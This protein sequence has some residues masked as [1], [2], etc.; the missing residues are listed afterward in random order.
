ML[1]GALLVLALAAPAFAQ[2]DS[3]IV[4][5]QRVGWMKVGMDFGIVQ[6][7]FGDSPC[8][9]GQANDMTVYSYDVQKFQFYVKNNKVVF[10]LTGNSRYRLASGV[11]IGSDKA[12]VVKA[13]GKP[14]QDG[15]FMV[16]ESGI[17]LRLKDGAV[18]EIVVIKTGGGEEDSSV[19]VAGRKDLTLVHFYTDG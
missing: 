4:P 14:A 7:A 10:V 8:K 3:L 5:G 18:S 6:K 1:L 12:S 15:Q 9:T 17:A 2:D 19:S 16:Y 13:L 11:T